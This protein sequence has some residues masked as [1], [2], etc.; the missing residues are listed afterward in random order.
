[1]SEIN[2]LRMMDHQGIMKLYEVH[3]THIAVYM[4]VELLQGGELFDKLK[5]RRSFAESEIALMLKRVI[6]PL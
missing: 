1:M 5:E 2:T 3:E 6:D 4:I